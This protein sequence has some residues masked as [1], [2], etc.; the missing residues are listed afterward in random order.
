LRAKADHAL[1]N[2]DFSAALEQYEIAR[3]LN[4]ADPYIFCGIALCYRGLSN[5][6]A[7]QESA[8]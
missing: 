2:G 5:F 7:M 3:A 8:E 4:A 1:N 6:E